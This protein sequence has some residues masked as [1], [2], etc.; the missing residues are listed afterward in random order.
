MQMKLAKYSTILKMVAFSICQSKIR[1]YKVKRQNYTQHIGITKQ[2]RLFERV[3]YL[4]EYQK[5]LCRCPDPG[6]WIPTSKCCVFPRPRWWC[7]RQLSNARFILVPAVGPYV[8]QRGCA[9]ALYYLAP[10]VLVVGV[11]A[12]REREGSSHISARRGVRY[13]DDRECRWP[14]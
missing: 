8:Q 4:W 13:G 11:Q 10:A 14:Q 2:F 1:Y 3:K 7:K 12:R 6:A 9:R 5:Y